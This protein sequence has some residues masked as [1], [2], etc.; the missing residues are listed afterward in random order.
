[1]IHAIAR[2][3]EAPE[4]AE[5]IVERLETMYEA[6]DTE[7]RPDVV[8]YDA[9][10]N[11]FGWSTVEG[12]SR[13]C[14]DI[15]QKML[16]EYKSGKNLRVKPDIITCNSVLNSCAYE[17]VAGEAARAD[18]INMVVDTMETFQSEA[19]EFGWPNHVTYSH[20]LRAISKHLP[21]SDQKRTALAEATFWQCCKNGHV[22]VLV[23]TQLHRALP[24]ARFSELMGQALFSAADDVHLGFNLRKLPPEWTRFAPKKPKQRRESRPS[25]KEPSV[26]VT[27][28]VIAK[29]RGRDR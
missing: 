28:S 6:G 10:I 5:R 27:K 22:S 14:Y 13:R 29:A 15:F 8:C 3:R 24:W 2:S 19:P 20:V 7:V 1:V 23:V 26:E 21:P 4:R 16:R 12:R 17:E 9:L 11:A 25:R 18:M